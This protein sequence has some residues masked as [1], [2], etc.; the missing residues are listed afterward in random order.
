M[1]WCRRR[2]LRFLEHR[3]DAYFHLA[4]QYPLGSFADEK[5]MYMVQTYE[6]FASIIRPEQGGGG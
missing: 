5:C 6:F 1:D 2:L 4:T 3:R